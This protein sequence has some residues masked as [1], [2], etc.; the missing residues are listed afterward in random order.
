V[1][2]EY[3][4]KNNIKPL[5]NR[6]KVLEYL[7]DKQNHPTVD[8]IYNDLVK[9]LPT[10][11]KTTVYNTLKLFLQANLVRLITIEDNETRYDVNIPNHGHFKC[12]ECK[13]IYDFTIDIDGV[14][15]E[16]LSQFK[17]K[18]K[19]VYY[20]GICPGCLNKKN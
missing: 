18:E 2:H 13:E 16:E 5:Y 9:E 12:E 15:T 4:V 10:L 17:I 7:L 3:L 20:K 19:S 14:E 1:V 8:E 11:S 6:V